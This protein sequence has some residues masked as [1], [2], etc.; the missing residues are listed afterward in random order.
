MASHIY[1]SWTDSTQSHKK[2]AFKRLLLVFTTHWI[3]RDL[4]LYLCVFSYS[5]LFC[6][7]KKKPNLHTSIRELLYH[8]LV[9]ILEF[10]RTPACVGMDLSASMVQVWTEILWALTETPSACMSVEMPIL[11]RIATDE[12]RLL[13]RWWKFWVIFWTCQVL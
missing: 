1:F 9:N 12:L 4:Y 6:W 11:G 5:S 7:W 8:A 10:D 3:P 13:W 2:A